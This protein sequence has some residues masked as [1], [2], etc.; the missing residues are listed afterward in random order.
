MSRMIED[1]LD[2]T[3]ARLA[4]GIPITRA[5]A[6]SAHSSRAWSQEHEASSRGR[7]IEVHHEGNLAGEWDGDRLAQVLANLIGNALQHGEGHEP[8]EVHVEGSSDHVVTCRWRTPAP[9][10]PSG[11]AAHLR[12][13]PQRPACRKRPVGLGLGLYIAQ[14]IVHAHHGTIDVD[15]SNTTHTVFTVTVPR[16]A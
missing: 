6:I 1:M 3:R 2:L 15:S 8:V 5:A 13:V 7:R 16:R 12:S 4:G 10:T 9:S 11:A 14:Q